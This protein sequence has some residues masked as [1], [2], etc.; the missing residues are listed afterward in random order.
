MDSTFA[1]DFFSANVTSNFA[2]RDKKTPGTTIS[3]KPSILGINF[4]PLVSHCTASLLAAT[5]APDASLN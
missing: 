3:P 2:R 4:V 1:I 5:N